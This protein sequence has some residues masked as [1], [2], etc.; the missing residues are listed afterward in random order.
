MALVIP[1]ERRFALVLSALALALLVPARSFAQ[2][3]P[4]SS[5]VVTRGDATD[6][7]PDA[8]ALAE[9]VRR[10]TGADVI[11]S[12]GLTAGPRE[13]FIRVAISR[14]SAGFHA[15]ITA[16]GQRHGTRTLDDV[17]PTCTALEDAIA[18][19]IAIF[20]DPYASAPMP[21]PLAPAPVAPP[22]PR[23]PLLTTP[24]APARMD[25][26]VELDAGVAFGVLEDTVPLLA[27]RAGL[28]GSSRWS[29]AIGG[30]FAFPDTLTD[31]DRTVDLSLAYG[32]AALC[33]R[34]LGESGTA[35]LD[36]C[37]EPMVGRFTGTGHGYDHDSTKHALWIAGAAGPELV[38]P[39][40]GRF[41]WTA[42]ALG[43]IPFLRQS[44]DITRGGVDY[45]LFHAPATAALLAFG[46]R[47]EL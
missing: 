37:L 4:K 21:A 41:A 10:L 47:G 28:R 18:V 12:S 2:D 45:A 32:Y 31:R 5:L 13:T 30:A 39:I 24:P 33:G 16:G 8:P 3:A 15:D 7:C 42:S 34:A 43:V 26:F 1:S 38:L 36:W 20:L 11:D 35:H 23:V 46:L 40:A 29:V 9:Q 19:T 17:G 44:F 22:S 14:N 27:A 25:A 6:T